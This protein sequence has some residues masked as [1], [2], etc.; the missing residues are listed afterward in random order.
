M[1][2]AGE[3]ILRETFASI[4]PSLAFEHDTLLYS[5]YAVSALHLAKD[6]PRN[7]EALDA[8]QKYLGLTLRE[9]RSE[10][11]R[12]S[13]AN[14]DAACLTSTF[15]RICAFAMLQERP[16][17]P[18]TPPSQWLQMTSGSVNVFRESWAWIVDDE[19]SVARRLIMKRTPML[20]PFNE[21]LFQESNRQG[22]LHLLRRGGRAND[23]SEPWDT[24]IE[25][26]YKSTL[27]YLGGIQIAIA[28]HEAPTDIGRRI[29][30]FPMMVKKRF[31]QLIE[32]RQPRALVVLAHFFAL[33]ARFSDFWWLGDTGKRE[34][35]GI[36][37]VLPGEWQDLMS[38]PL[39][40]MEEGSLLLQK[41]K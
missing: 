15:L 13:K 32:E 27:S 6:E 30:I 3:S 23:T 7:L 12:L 35:R 24:D 28:A 17:S 4:I 40:A 25:E 29:I 9:H 18:Y 21:T 1:L 38:W 20:V 16:L 33:L 37:T 11:A 10:V 14:A 31:I 26:A 5:I 2:G 41:R 34:I 39:A 8:Y 36:Q 22:L 19:A